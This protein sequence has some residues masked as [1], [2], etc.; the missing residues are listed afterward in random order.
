MNLL[1]Q[2]LHR[3]LLLTV[4]LALL[5][6]CATEYSNKDPI[7]QL[8]P[9]ISGSSLDQKS[10]QIPQDLG[11]EKTLLLIGYKQ[12]A[13]FDIDRWMIGIDMSGTKVS[14]IELPAIQ[15]F[16]PRLFKSKIDEGMRSGIPE[17]LWPVVVTVY[18]DGRRVQSFT[19]NESPSNARVVLL[20]DTGRVIYF[21][22]RGFSVDALNDLKTAVLRP[23]SGDIS[24]SSKSTG[25]NSS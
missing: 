19:G 17:E 14:I 18:E 11:D 23:E 10:Y 6:G 8:F 25:A 13:Q 2:N 7:G 4:T 20:N 1:N 22:D 9:S 21:Y 12:N 24:Q 16:L 15:G 5:G 3:V